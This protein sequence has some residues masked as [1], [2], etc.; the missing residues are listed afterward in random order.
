MNL[1]RY[2]IRYT[3]KLVKNIKKIWAFCGL[4]L[5]PNL[6]FSNFLRLLGSWRFCV[7]RYY[8]LPTSKLELQ[9]TSLFPCAHPVVTYMYLNSNKFMLWWEIFG[10]DG[11]FHS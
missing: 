1:L 2:L 7:I 4:I 9:K 5:L 8:G 6:N 3:G 10:C 11:S